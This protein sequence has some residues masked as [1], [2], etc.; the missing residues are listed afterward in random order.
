MLAGAGCVHPASSPAGS[1]TPGSG[2]TTTSPA[3]VSVDTADGVA[4]PSLQ[5]AVQGSDASQVVDLLAKG[6]DPNS[7][8]EDGRPVLFLT[9]N[10][11]TPEIAQALLDK[12]AKIDSRDSHGE[13]P[14]MQAIF[15]SN[16]PLVRTLLD[17]HADPNQPDRDG[18][19]PLV[20]A[21]AQDDS[22]IVKL[23]LER[24]ANRDAVDREGD[25]ALRAATR[26]ENAELI[27]LLSHTPAPAPKP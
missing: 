9:T 13:T 11:P 7:K 25:T 3:L 18:D 15:H 22:A 8:T 21:A 12:G 26:G 5:E 6:A 2:A 27:A 10:K 23:L 20:M 19:L 14:L 4:P 16:L 1:A 17:H 24:G